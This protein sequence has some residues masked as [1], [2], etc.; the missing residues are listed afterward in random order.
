MSFRVIV[1]LATFSLV[2]CFVV[3][4]LKATKGSNDEE[5]AALPARSE[6][7]ARSRAL[8]LHE[9]ANGAL[10]VMHRDF[11]DDENPR[12]IPSASLEDVFIEMEKTFDVKMKWLTVNT[13]VVNFA[14]QAKSEFEKAAV[15]ALAS[16]ERISE[17]VSDARYQFA[18]AIRL[19][20][21]CLKCHV[22]NRT[23]TEDRTAA[24]VISMPLA[25]S[26]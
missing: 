12:A 3:A 6:S 2:A 5:L 4:E 26:Q 11:F 13:D 7:E 10:Q 22:K 17:G 21:Q 20:S 25:E 14:N 19:R 24:L 1:G 18:G 16:G 15:K 9:M 23:D 8:L